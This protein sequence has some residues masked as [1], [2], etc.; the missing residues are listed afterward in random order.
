MLEIRVMS[1]SG[2]PFKSYQVIS[3]MVIALLAC[4]FSPVLLIFVGVPMKF[5]TNLLAHTSV[6]KVINRVI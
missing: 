6:K 3:F 1:M 5:I 4:H 2:P